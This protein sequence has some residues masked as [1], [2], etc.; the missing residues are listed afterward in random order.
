MDSLEGAPGLTGNNGN[1]LTKL[2]DLSEEEKRQILNSREFSRFFQHT[3]RVIER[4]LA[5]D[6][7]ILFLQ[8]NNN[9]PSYYLFLYFKKKDFQ[10]DIFT[11]Y[12]NSSAH[13]DKIDKGEF[14]ILNREFTQEQTNNRIV[15]A[16]DFSSFYPELVAVAYDRNVDTPL[17]PEGIINVWNT[18]FKTP[19]EYKFF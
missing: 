12:I 4:A 19:P 2:P 13:D 7:I 8:F 14:L 17:A 11:D 5:E 15:R 9:S 16:M 18:N 10:V 6:V 3:A 1:A